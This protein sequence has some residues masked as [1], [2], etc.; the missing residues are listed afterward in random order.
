ME[1]SITSSS[2]FF[3]SS[4]SSNMTA[5]EPPFKKKN[6]LANRIFKATCF[7]EADLPCRL[8]A[9]SRRSGAPVQTGLSWRLGSPA[10]VRCC[11]QSTVRSL[12]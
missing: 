10:I 3:I 7:G 4:I 12:S 6:L 11:D 2:Y 5:S 8:R 1:N 9:A